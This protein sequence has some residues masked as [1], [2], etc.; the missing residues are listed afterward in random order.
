MCIAHIDENVADRTNTSMSTGLLEFIAGGV[1]VG[2]MLPAYADSTAALQRCRQ[3]T[4]S[5]ERITCYDSIP[6]PSAPAVGA[7]TAMPA[8]SAVGRETASTAAATSSTPGRPKP[9]EPVTVIVELDPGFGLPAKQVM[10]EA[11]ES[12]ITGPFDGWVADSRFT[13]ANGQVWE[14]SDGSTAGYS[15]RRNSNVRIARGL[16]GSFFMQIEGVSQ[17]PRVR[18]L[19]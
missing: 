13:L 5:Q 1:L 4:E 16:L 3:I 17:S 2:S 18:R 6:I 11:L 14:I 12:S 19:K 7:A 8:A 10:L 9:A 15:S